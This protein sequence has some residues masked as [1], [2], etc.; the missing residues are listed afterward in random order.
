MELV[1]SALGRMT[2]IRQIFPL[3]RDTNIRCMR[4][5]HRI[6][7]LLCDPQEGYL[8]SLEVS[9]LYLYDSVLMLANAFYRKLEDRKW[10]SMASLNCMRKSTKPWNGGWS[11]LDTIQKGRISGLTGLMDFRSNGA[12]SHVQFEILGTSYSETFGKDVKRIGKPSIF[13]KMDLFPVLHTPEQFRSA[14]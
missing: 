7:S 8:Q 12:N 4:N 14:P 11:M 5:N 6:S 9:S 10:H 2:V 3:W 1:H 13:Y